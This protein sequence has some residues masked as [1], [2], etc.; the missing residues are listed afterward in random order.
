MESVS[1]QRNLSLDDFENSPNPFCKLLAI[2]LNSGLGKKKGTVAF[3][4]EKK[5]EFN[6]CTKKRGPIEAPGSIEKGDQA[7][8]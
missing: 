2:V 3:T 6:E 4:K 1:S 5:K 7:R 8:E